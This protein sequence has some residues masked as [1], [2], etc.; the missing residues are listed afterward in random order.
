MDRHRRALTTPMSST[1][2]DV[3]SSAHAVRGSVVRACF[4]FANSVK[5]AMR[6]RAAG[7]PDAIRTTTFMTTE[8]RLR[9]ETTGDR[10]HR[11]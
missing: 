8:P 2:P 4:G 3:K 7:T 1:C 11:R 5:P 6:Y 9:G 10:H